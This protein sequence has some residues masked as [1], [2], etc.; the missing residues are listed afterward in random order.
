M[1]ICTEHTTTVKMVTGFKCS[2]CGMATEDEMETQESHSIII[3]GG[4]S[5]VFGDGALGRLDICQHCLK[6]KLGEFI[7]WEEY[8]EEGNPI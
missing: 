2:I 5:S 8:D 3:S 1:L 7:E 4:Y 6:T